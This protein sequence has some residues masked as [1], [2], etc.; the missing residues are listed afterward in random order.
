[1]SDDVPDRPPASTMIEA[2]EIQKNAIVGLVVGVIVAVVAYLFRVLE[3]LGP[4]AGGRE[5][6]VVG[7]EGWFLLLAIVFAAA[8]ALLVMLVLTGVRIVQITRDV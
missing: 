2:L 5:Y 4:A 7:P 6:P 3:L 1:V 8:T